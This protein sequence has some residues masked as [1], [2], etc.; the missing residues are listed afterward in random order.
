MLPDCAYHVAMRFL[1]GQNVMEGGTCIGP[2]RGLC[3]NADVD[4]IGRHPMATLSRHDLLAKT[5]AEMCL[6]VT[7]S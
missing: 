4:C 5:C 7:G 2:R 3:C 1:L 6:D